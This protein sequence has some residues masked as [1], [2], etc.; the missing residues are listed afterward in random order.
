MPDS[1]NFDG[2]ASDAIYN[3]VGCLANEPLP[4]S[5]D[6]TFSSNFGM[7]G[8]IV[9]GFPHSLSH[10]LGG[11]WIISGNVLLCFYEVG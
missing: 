8:Q 1:E 4:S 10:G 9:R 3:Q 6:V 11:R 7:V 2:I 5:L